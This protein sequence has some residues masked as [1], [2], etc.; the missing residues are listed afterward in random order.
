MAVEPECASNNQLTE[1]LLTWLRNEARSSL[2]KIWTEHGVVDFIVTRPYQELDP[3]IYYRL[4]VAEI[5]MSTPS[6]SLVLTIIVSPQKHSVRWRSPMFE[7]TGP[8][9][10]LS[11]YDD[12]IGPASKLGHLLHD[13]AMSAQESCM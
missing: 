4:G 3:T 2:T 5:A 7:R 9:V 1:T 6:A 13:I 8:A 10:Q 12:R 11:R